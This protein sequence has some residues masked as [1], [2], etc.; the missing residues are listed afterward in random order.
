MK[1]SIFRTCE[2]SVD[3]IKQILDEFGLDYTVEHIDAIDEFA[4]ELK[5]SKVDRVGNWDKWAT[6]MHDYIEKFTVSKYGA[7]EDN[8]DFDLM[9]ITEPRIC[10]WNILKYALRLW[11]NKGKINDLHKICHYAEMAWTL[12][13]G[14][15]TK[16]G[17]TNEKST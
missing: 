16:A 11:K 6:I 15:L 12:S 3:D 7:G 1:K 4:I 9:T 5:T 8:D 2:E 13:N 14:D 10:I 17:I